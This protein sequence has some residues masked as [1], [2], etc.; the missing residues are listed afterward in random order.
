MKTFWPRSLLARN[1]V[2]LILLVT[3]TQFTTLSVFLVFIQKP[4]VN[5]AAS[6]I[7][8]QIMMLDKLLATVPAAD[9]NRYVQAVQGVEQPPAHLIEIPTLGLTGFYRRYYLKVFLNSLHQQL[10]AGMKLRWEQ[11]QKKL[12]VEVSIAGKPYWVTLSV[13]PS[14]HMTSLISAIFLSIG[15]SM[16]A[17]L[18]AYGLQRRINRP[19]TSL[20]QAATDVGKG[21]WPRPLS[22]EGP[23]EIRIVSQ[24]FN[25]M[26]DGLAEMENTRAQMLAG[27]SH[28]LRTPLTK[29]RLAMAISGQGATNQ[30]D[31]SRYFD[32]V[33]NILQQFIDYA[34]GSNS[35]QSQAGDI[36]Q[37]ITELA[38]DF[39]GLGHNFNLALSP[40]PIFL[41][42]PVSV[43]RLLTNLMQNAA[44]YGGTGLEV[45]SWQEDNAA[46]IAVQD[47]GPGAA[48]EELLLM[49][50][51]FHRGKGSAARHNGAGLG[52]AI[53]SQIAQQHGG[54][55]K[56]S[57][58]AGG[59]LTVLVT[60]PLV[61]DA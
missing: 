39:T 60:L 43:M 52:L 56:V 48:E 10:P 57:K 4:R 55:L 50:K 11:I 7:A 23:S 41:F 8:S 33:D 54:D 24:T 59:G 49:T 38:N 20:A 32:D 16:L 29:L 40:L 36:N 12:W 25:H 19:L 51:P 31:V 5:D 30:A 28:D 34:R 14:D 1:S 35:E 61:L 17:L 44:K 2:L 37:M 58:R 26:L 42:K 53:A 15:L 6:L 45:A 18:T 13:E 46:I 9:R 22:P 3:L 27:I 21:G 47:R